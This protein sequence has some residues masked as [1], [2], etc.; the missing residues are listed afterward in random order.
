MRAAVP[1]I[2]QAAPTHFASA[3]AVKLPIG[4]A[5]MYTIT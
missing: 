3:P 4:E 2:A 5:P 1:P